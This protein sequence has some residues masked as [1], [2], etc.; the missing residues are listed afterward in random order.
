MTRTLVDGGLVLCDAPRWRDDRLW[1]SD[2]YAGG[3][4]TTT[5]DGETEKVLEVA[6]GPAGI[7]FPDDG[8]WLVVSQHDQK[9]LRVVDGA[10]DVYADLSGI[11]IGNCNELLLTPDGNAYVGCFGFEIGDGSA[12]LQ[13]RPAPLMLIRPDGSVTVVDDDLMFPNGMV[14]TPDGRT[15]LVNQTFADCITAFD[16]Q[17]DGSLT[18][19][20]VWAELPGTNPDGLCLDAEGAVW[21]A[22]VYAGECIRVAEGGET[23]SRVETPGR[24]LTACMLGGPDRRH[25]F[26]LTTETDLERLARNE[27]HGRVEVVEVQVPGAGLP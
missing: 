7:A 12:E 25:L 16:V 17:P 5:L 3:V 1:F 23:L 14:L 20:R 9:I 21:V 26:V 13:P 6:G 19:R 11:A 2:L 18:N 8:S 27:G 22:C 4:Y 10:T 24:W 15:L